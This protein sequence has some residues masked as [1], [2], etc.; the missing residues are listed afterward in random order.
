MFAWT[1]SLEIGVPEIDAQHRSLF[2]RANRF[3][4]AVQSREPMHRLEELFAFLAEYAME[5]FAAEERFMR[6]IGYPQLMEH[7]NEH[8]QFRRQLSS[9]VPQWNTEGESTAVLLGLL[10]FLKSWLTEHIAGSDQRIGD[11][12]RIRR[13]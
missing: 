13:N 9:L 2:E 3:A 6:E 5:H 4:T 11:Y 1:P 10:S 8:R 7:M 12:A